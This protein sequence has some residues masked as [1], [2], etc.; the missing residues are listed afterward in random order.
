MFNLNHVLTLGGEKIIINSTELMFLS[1]IKDV[2][3]T[4]LPPQERNNLNKSLKAQ[5]CYDIH[6]HDEC[7]QTSV[8]CKLYTWWCSVPWMDC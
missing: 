8:N 7:M 2:H 4:T 3:C 1:S 5:Y 6:V